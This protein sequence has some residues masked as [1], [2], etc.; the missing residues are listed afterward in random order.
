[1]GNLEASKK[2]RGQQEAMK[3]T[4]EASKKPARGQQ[5]EQEVSKRTARGQQEASKMPARSQEEAPN[6]G[7]PTKHRNQ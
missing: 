2:P 7:D 5:A 6:E 1:M 4:I 3:R